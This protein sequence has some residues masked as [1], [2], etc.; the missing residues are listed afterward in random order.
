MIKL[1]SE[2]MGHDKNATLRHKV[3]I[4]LDFLMFLGQSRAEHCP[5]GLIADKYTSLIDPFDLNEDAR[6]RNEVLPG[7]SMSECSENSPITVH[8]GL[9]HADY[10]RVSHRIEPE[11][12]SL[13]VESQA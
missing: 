13:P 3:V 7:F 4:G 11:F 9:R 10:S 8:K 2:T 12:L 1:A 5:A 6:T